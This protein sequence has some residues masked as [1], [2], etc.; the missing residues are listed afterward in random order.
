MKKRLTSTLALLLLGIA[1]IALAYFVGKTIEKNKPNLK[2]VLEE[3]QN[4]VEEPVKGENTEGVI[5]V[6]RIVDGDTLVISTGETVRL[7]GIDTPEKEDCYSTN[8][9]NRLREL[10]LDKEISIEY[11]QSEKDRYSRT[12]LYVW[13]NG[14]FVNEV[15]V[16]EGYADAKRYPPNIKYASVLEVAETEARS[17]GLGIW[18]S[19]PCISAF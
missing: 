6:T 13:V 3:L 16:K 5:K 2:P 18:S 1:F 11:D 15:L 10:V 19:D 17:K 8:A 9:A 7:I 14:S 12:L 4:K